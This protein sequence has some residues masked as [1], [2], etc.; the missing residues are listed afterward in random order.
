MQTENKP[1]MNV[2]GINDR[3]YNEFKSAVYKR[4][5]KSVKS[6]VIDMMTEFI[7]ETNHSEK[8]N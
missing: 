7:E 4:G 6:A 1:S 5:Y 2:R 8:Y 3:L